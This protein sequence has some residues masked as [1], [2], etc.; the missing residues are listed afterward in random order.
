[1]LLNTLIAA[2]VATAALLAYRYKYRFITSSHRVMS[3]TALTTYKG[4]LVWVVTIEWQQKLGG[5][6]VEVYSGD[7]TNWIIRDSDWGRTGRAP[8]SALWIVLNDIVTEAIE[9][10]AAPKV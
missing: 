9:S 3:L 8:C 10:G 7:R 6:I 1:M 2:V 4:G 5:K